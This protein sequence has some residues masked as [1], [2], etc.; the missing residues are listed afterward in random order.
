M[1]ASKFIQALRPAKEVAV[2]L[3]PADA[4]NILDLALARLAH[5]QVTPE[6]LALLS[7]AAQLT[8]ALRS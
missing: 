1:D 3:D 7:L 5:P 4:R 8:K 2:T 6:Q